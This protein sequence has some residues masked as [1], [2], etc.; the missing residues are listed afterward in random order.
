MRTN[1]PLS[2][3]AG[4]AGE[5]EAGG[6]LADDLDGTRAMEGLG[7]DESA[8]PTGEFGRTTPSWSGW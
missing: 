2:G 3:D 4:G 6:L 8:R 1:L 5:E 7:E